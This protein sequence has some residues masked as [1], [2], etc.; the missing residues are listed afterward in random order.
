MMGLATDLESRAVIGRIAGATLVVL[1]GIVFG[2]V[3][4]IW[5]PSKWILLILLKTWPGLKCLLK[6][7]LYSRIPWTWMKW[8]VYNGPCNF[9][10]DLR[11]PSGFVNI[12]CV[13]H[14]S[15]P[16]VPCIPSGTNLFTS[17]YYRIRVIVVSG[18]SGRVL[19]KSYKGSFP[20]V[21]IKL[22]TIN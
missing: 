8:A 4:N 3:G 21:S 5:V 10:K 14:K 2:C 12:L 22:L 13:L 6:R 7:F 18:F 1:E 20:G 19:W 9:K 15:L 11:T 16:Y 17:A